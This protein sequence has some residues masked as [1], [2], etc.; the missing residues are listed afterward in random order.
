MQNPAGGF[1]TDPNNNVTLQGHHRY[2]TSFTIPAGK[3]LTIGFDNTFPDGFGPRGVLWVEAPTCTI[4]GTIAGNAIIAA[5]G[6]GVVSW[7]GA[8]GGGGG[9]DA[10]VNSGTAGNN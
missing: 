10:A 7:L 3:T 6:S 2:A 1:E 5:G 4:A 8:S 9:G